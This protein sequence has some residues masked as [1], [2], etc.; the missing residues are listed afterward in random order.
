MT[1]YELLTLQAAFDG[2]GRQAILQR[3]LQDEPVMP[4]QL[5]SAIPGDLETIVT[6]SIAKNPAERY[7]TAAALADDLE[8]FLADK[9]IRAKRPTLLKRAAKWSRRHQAVVWSV[10]ATLVVAV[11]ILAV[12]AVW[13]A[14]EQTRTVRALNQS[15]INHQ[16][17][18]QQHED[19]VSCARYSA[20]G[21]WIATAGYDG[22]IRICDARTFQRRATLVAGQGNL[23][24]IAF[25]PDGQ[26]LASAGEDG[27]VHIW[28]LHQ[29]RSVLKFSA[30]EGEAWDVVFSLDGKLLA[31]SG[32]DAVIRLWEPGTGQLLGTLEG[33]ERTIEEI[34]ISPDG[35]VLA[36]AS[37]DTDVKLWNLQTREELHHLDSHGFRVVS[38]AFSPDGKC[39]AT[40]DIDGKVC[41][42]NVEDGSCVFVAQQSDGVETVAFSPE[43]NW[44]ATGD[45]GGAIRCW[46]L[47]EPAATEPFACWQAHRG[48]IYA[49]TFS[50][51]ADRLVSSGRDGSVVA[52]KQVESGSRKPLTC[53]G[54]VNDFAYIPGRSAIATVAQGGVYVWDLQNEA[55]P[56]VLTE[57]DHGRWTLACSPDGQL[58]AV[59]AFDGGIRF[60][61][62]R[63]RTTRAVSQLD[64]G[65]VSCLAF[66][67]DGLRL[68]CVAGSRQDVVWLFDA[69]SGRLASTLPALTPGEIAFSPDG[70]LLAVSDSGSGDNIYLWDL[71]DRSLKC[72]L[73][74][75]TNTI[76]DLAFS[77]DGGLI[78]S[79][80]HDRLVKLWDWQTGTERSSLS[81]HGDQ[82]D[83]LA[84]SPDGVTLATGAQDGHLMFWQVATGRLLLDMALDEMP[85]TTIAFDASGN[86]LA[87]LQEDSNEV[88]LI[89]AETED[90]ETVFGRVANAASGT[91]GIEQNLSEQTKG[92]IRQFALAGREMELAG[93]A[94]DGTDFDWSAYRG[95][96][97]LV[98][99]WEASPGEFHAQLPEV[100]RNYEL[101]RNRG[102]DVVGISLDR[103]HQV[104][105]QVLKKEQL[106]WVTLHSRNTRGA[107]PIA[108]HYGIVHLPMMFLID[109]EGK[110]IFDP[111]PRQG[112][113]QAVGG[114][115]WAAGCSQPNMNLRASTCSA[116]PIGM[117]TNVS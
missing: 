81:G 86:C 13:I 2:S 79:A 65:S 85:I 57:E 44:L 58:L 62:L 83:E 97:V 104:L 95:K 87:C 71:G 103:D 43:G 92:L 51:E 73:A 80:S 98:V 111:R 29:E 15:R 112:V 63:S 47:G 31:S 14:R 70:R 61:D 28:D 4:R 12:S 91:E 60:W 93:T 75:H 110:V 88:L 42:W 89:D 99:F 20:D 32:D 76:S 22:V 9:P 55:D 21:Q 109:R 38:V 84:F 64:Q 33:H 69:R 72:V 17:A 24:G 108:A 6:K 100:K 56:I 23:R 50:P 115:A 7:A 45:R 105:Q 10:V 5:N 11:V 30:H 90:S 1:L 49:V 40:T 59:G 101:Y 67:P 117:I 36:S 107:H 52:W 27:I 102:F 48:R 116:E 78:A 26:T 96:V 74:G 77:P 106:P 53:P 68:A 113:G 35:R 41:V 46:N 34:D 82:I 18:K 54:E 114:I 94:V 8:R 16:D 25:A 37:S 39:V 66:S 19:R 3:I